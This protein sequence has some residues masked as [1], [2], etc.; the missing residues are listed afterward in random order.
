MTTFE[1]LFGGAA[2]VDA[3]CPGRVNLIGEHTDYQAGLVLPVAL[4]LGTRVELRPRGDD[5][6]RVFSASQAAAGVVSFRVSAESKRGDW[7]DYL[8]GVTAAGR[9]A[10]LRMS[11]F[12]ARITT[13]LPVGGG[14]ASSAA[15]QV[16]LLRALRAGLQLPAD[17]FTLAQLAHQAE[18]TFVGVPVGWMDQLACSFGDPTHALFLDTRTLAWQ[19]V[20]LPDGLRLVVIE[21]GIPHRNADGGYR[22]RRRQVEEAARLLGVAVLRDLSPADLPRVMRLPDPLDRRARH[23][24][25]E[26][27]RVLAFR[28]ALEAGTREQLGPI[29]AAAH[30]SLRADYEVSVLE[31]DR[32]VAIATS[33]P[34]VLGA[35]LTGGGFGGSVVLLAQEQEAAAAAATV[36]ARYQRE[37][38][39]VATV[40]VIQP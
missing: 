10:G 2:T 18:T 12:D 21:S 7:V 4:S 26:N 15:L 40:V 6:V 19:K 8:Q 25:T 32:L 37:T 38:G 17:D 9:A 11:G 27:A 13:D 16:A 34:G 28:Q 23:V 35:R 31:I 36:A 24:I 5:T 39:R 14:L 3:W 33:V 1:N 22:E 30:D 20:A 29:L